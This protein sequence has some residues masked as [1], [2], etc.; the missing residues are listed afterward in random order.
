[1]FRD[2]SLGRAMG[3]SHKENGGDLGYM[4]ART[5][6]GRGYATEMGR[7]LIAEGFAR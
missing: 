3:V 6:W 1:V 4:F 2:G 7:A 5:D